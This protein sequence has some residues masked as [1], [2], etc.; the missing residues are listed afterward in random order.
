MGIL[1][2]IGVWVLLVLT[3]AGFGK[4]SV[5]VPKLCW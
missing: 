5:S 1:E 4:I 3:V 2:K